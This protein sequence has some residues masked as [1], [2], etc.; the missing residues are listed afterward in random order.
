MEVERMTRPSVA[1]ARAEYQVLTSFIRARRTLY[2]TLIVALSLVWATV[3]APYIMGTAI[4]AFMSMDAIRG[5]LMFMF[6]GVMRSLMMLIWLA[7]LLF[8]LSQA[9]QEIRIGQWEIFLSN[10]VNTRSILTGTFLGKIPLYGVVVIL[11]APLVISPFMLAF[12]VSIIGQLLVYGVFALLAL[13]AIWLSNLITAVIQARL[14]D[15]SRGNDLAKAISMV[16][17]IIVVVPMYGLMFFLPTISEMMGANVMLVLPSTWFADLVTWISAFFNGVSLTPVEIGNFASIL[18]MDMWVSSVLLGAWVLGTIGLGL[19]AADR[20]FTIDAGVRTEVVTTAGKENV[21]LRGIRKASPGPFGAL[22]VTTFKDF[23][24]KAQ[25]LSKIG[26]GTVLAVLLPVIMT[27][28]D[29]EFVQVREFFFMLVVMMSLVGAFPFAGT[30]FLESRD[31]LWIIQ[32]APDGA[33]RF[34]RSRVASQLIMVLPLVAI[35]TVFLT[36]ILEMTIVELLLVFVCGYLAAA[37]GML[38]ATGITASNP[39]YEDT[40]SPAHQA[41]I[42][43]SVLLAEFSIIGVVITDL[44]LTLVLHID[45][46]GLIGSILGPSNIMYGM[47]LMGVAVQWALGLI[48]VWRGIRSL[49]RPDP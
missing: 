7:L 1:I 48:I 38:I 20:V 25:N 9:L 46:F 43:T 28:F 5:L 4:N 45:L 30:G 29:A 2:M 34:V 11:L 35:P 37:G 32:G 40:K 44:I 6:P 24:R 31:Q 26:Y 8:P 39:N 33:K 15:S 16:I 47:T 14:G 17:A 18:Q 13:S 41:N 12:E 10:D 22:M 42:M 27:S 21:F 49:S 3:V 36:F 19:W 23:M